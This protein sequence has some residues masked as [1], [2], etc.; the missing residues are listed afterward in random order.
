MAG[1]PPKPADQRRRQNKDPHPTTSVAADG[2]QRGPD[3][4]DDREWPERTRAWWE[5]WRSSAQSQTF[6]PT[7]WDFL[8]DT[9]VFHAAVWEGTLTAGPELRLRMSKFGATQ[10]DRMRL[11]LQVDQEVAQVSTESR[12]AAPGRRARLL[13]AV[14]DGA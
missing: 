11:R 9:A 2:V 5:T 8:L 13:K 10:E 14:G 6:T 4:P 12:A 1:P 7:D 3:L